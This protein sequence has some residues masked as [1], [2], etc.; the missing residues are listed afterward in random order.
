[1]P[2]KL[3]ILFVYILIL[4]TGCAKNQEPPVL[5][6]DD[7]T[8]PIETEP[9]DVYC[10]NTLTTILYEDQEYTVMGA[11]SVTLTDLLL[12]LAYDP[13]K[14]CECAD[15]TLTVTTEFG[16]PYYISLNESYARCQNDQGFL[17]GQADLTEEQLQTIKTILQSLE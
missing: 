16:G 14:I 15:Y 1:M 3:L 8:A 11:P 2:K 9:A 13:G 4:L 12:H 10:S 6:A 17:A 7:D 5:M